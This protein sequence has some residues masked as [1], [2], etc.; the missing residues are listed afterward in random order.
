MSNAVDFA[1]L[2]N[3]AAKTVDYTK[4]SEG[5]KFERELPEA[6]TCLVRLREYIEMGLCDT[7]SAAYPNKKPARKARFVFEVVTPKHVKT[8]ELEGGATMKIAPNIAIT[9][10]IS[11]NK[12]SNFIKLFRQLNWD[13]KAVHP[14]QLL[15]RGYMA[16]IVHAWKKGDDPKKDKP[17]YANLQKDGMYTIQ[18]PRVVDPLAGTTTNI[19]VP[20]LVNDKKL[21]LWDNPTKECWDS[22]FIDGEYE[23]DGK[24]VS[25]NWVQEMLMEALDFQT[26][27]LFE[28]LEGNGVPLDLPTTK[29]EAAAA[30]EKPAAPVETAAQVDPLANLGI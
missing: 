6:G 8:V 12:K 11:D 21:F 2:A 20:E 5:A 28:M 1:A 30:T 9:V 10:V 14:A 17:S 22:L 19:N 18:P 29:E 3:A 24:M 7:A 23:K 4:E 16:E 15:G 26:S 27:K 13:G 25:K